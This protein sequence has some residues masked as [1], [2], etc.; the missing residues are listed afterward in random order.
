M[1]YQD[2]I[3]IAHAITGNV[4][5]EEAVKRFVRTSK[6]PRKRSFLER[7]QKWS[8]ALEFLQFYAPLTHTQRRTFDQLVLCQLEV[9]Q[10]R[11]KHPALAEYFNMLHGI[12]A[13]NACNS[14][15]K[16]RELVNKKEAKLLVVLSDEGT[17]QE[18]SDFLKVSMVLSDKLFPYD[19]T[20]QKKLKTL[21]AA[22]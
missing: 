18:I 16:L 7:V 3:V 22:I 6:Y 15:E 2:R 20:M 14:A 21:C 13:H 17:Q 5:E 10:E 4:F 11:V 8:G 19:T 1:Q 9:C 12:A